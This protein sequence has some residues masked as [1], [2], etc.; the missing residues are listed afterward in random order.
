[1]VSVL[2]GYGVF[3]RYDMSRPR[4]RG[5]RSRFAQLVPQPIVAAAYRLQPHAQFFQDPAQGVVRHIGACL[6]GSQVRQGGEG[7][8][9][10][11]AGR[12]RRQALAPMPAG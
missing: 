9:D 8:I 11:Q 5:R 2:S 12:R 7:R 10:D 3:T 4:A 6:D 1:M